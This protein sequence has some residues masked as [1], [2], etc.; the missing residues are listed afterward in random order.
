MTRGN[1]DK[2]TNGAARS[3]GETRRRNV[4]TGSLVAA[5]VAGAT[6]PGTMWV[7]TPALR[8]RGS[9]PNV[10]TIAWLTYAGLVAED[11]RAEPES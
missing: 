8:R 7:L 6:K 9:G 10:P 5:K 1:P 2:F 3:P 11:V 4:A